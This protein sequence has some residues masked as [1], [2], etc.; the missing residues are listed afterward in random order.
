MSISANSDI[1][2]L[3]GVGERRSALYNKLGIFTVYDL[4]TYY[5]RKY[6]DFTD[7][8]PI[9][10]LEIGE[11]SA[12]KGRVMNRLTPWYSRGLTVYKAVISDGSDEIV[13][14]IFN[15][16]YSFN[17]LLIGKEFYFYG[18]IGGNILGKEIGSPEFISDDDFV[19][20]RPKYSLTAGLS[21]EMI[22]KHLK[23]AMSNIVLEDLIPD[24]LIK[25]HSLISFSD[26]VFKIHFPKDEEDIKKARKRLIFEEFLSLQLAMSRLKNKNRQLTSI[27]FNNLN[28]DDFLSTMP[29]TPTNAQMRSINECL[30]D[31]GKSFPM[32]RLLQGDVGSGKTL[33]AAAICWV[34][35]KSNYQSAVMVPTEILAKQ[36]YT[37]FSSMLKDFGISCALLIGSMSA[38]EKSKVKAELKNGEINIIIGTHTLIQKSVKF[39]NLG[40][41]IADEQHRFGVNQRFGLISKGKNPHCLVMSATPIPRTLALMIYG[42]LDISVIDE[43]PKGR[44]PVITYCVDSSFHERLYKFII[45]YVNMD[46][47]PI[48]FVL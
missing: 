43:M 20:I 36:H 7:V 8:K 45:K 10:Q 32:N 24:Y 29:F 18:K 27:K 9:S 30:S 17:K 41:V 34:A 23:T 33:V 38:A 5:P 11:T 15:S 2:Y 14:V 13:A 25:K 22:I 26:A 42:D 44:L 46:F 48:L 35:A 47:K 31:F 37:T 16:E 28:I 21:N 19:K 12:F 40:L 4:I 6:V 1:T 3:K 39:N